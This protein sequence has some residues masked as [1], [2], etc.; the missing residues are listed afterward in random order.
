MDSETEIDRRYTDLTMIIRPD[1]RHFKI[2]DILIEF[3]YVALGDAKLTGEKVRSMD[4]KELD[5][6]SCI[7]ESMDAAIKQGQKGDV[8]DFMLFFESFNLLPI[9]T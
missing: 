9:K 5:H 4:Q 7:K 2:F 8:Y 1:K 3:K 6:L